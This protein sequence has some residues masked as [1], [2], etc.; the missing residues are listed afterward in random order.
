MAARTDTS[1]P[2]ES[3]GQRP[4]PTR[5]GA[6]RP[7][8]THRCC[9]LPLVI[10]SGSEGVITL[11]QGS[12][13]SHSFTPIS[14]VTS[15]ARTLRIRQ[16][17]A[18]ARS[19]VGDLLFISVISIGASLCVVSAMLGVGEFAD[20]GETY[21]SI[22]LQSSAE[23]LM[24]SVSVRQQQQQHEKVNLSATVTTLITSE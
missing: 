15:S 13:R 19:H 21:S 7:L 18:R 10:N 16:L 8:E 5:S 6:E 12:G 4:A 24:S 1:L 22:N 9:P 11:A 20:A 14:S 2:L 3:C 17:L 23:C